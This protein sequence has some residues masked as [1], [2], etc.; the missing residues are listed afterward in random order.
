MCYAR[1][2]ILHIT[3]KSTW[4]EA[5][6]LG[7]YQADT[8]STQGFIHCSRKE[9]VV[10][11]ANFLFKGRSDLVL[12]LIKESRVTAEIKEEDGGDG[13]FFPHIYGPLNLDAVIAV[14]DFPSQDDGT[15]ILP[16]TLDIRTTW[17]E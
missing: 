17:S 9:Q 12:L 14:V 7:A 6:K 16:S 1:E 2:M 15:F 3:P 10:P 5:K 13:E 11:V 4:E 8:L